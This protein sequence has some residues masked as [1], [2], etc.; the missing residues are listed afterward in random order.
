[1]L[2][3]KAIAR[4]VYK[5]RELGAVVDELTGREGIKQ[6][7]GAL[8]VLTNNIT[9]REEYLRIATACA[10]APFMHKKLY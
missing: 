6:K 1:M 4:E 7:E 2:L 5:G 3:P 9:S 8:G 10:L